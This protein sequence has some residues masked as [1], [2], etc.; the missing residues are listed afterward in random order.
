MELE[1]VTPLF[2]GPL[3]SSVTVVVAKSSIVGSNAYESKGF[4]ALRDWGLHFGLTRSRVSTGQ[5]VD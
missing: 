2:L 1:H 4:D 5:F 3:G